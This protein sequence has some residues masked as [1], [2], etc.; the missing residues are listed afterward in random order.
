MF[1]QRNRRNRGTS[2][3]VI[4]LIQQLLT[5]GPI[6]PITL[7]F[8]I[9]Q[10]VIFMGYIPFMDPDHTHSLCLLPNVIINKKT[11]LRI[12]LPVL[13]HADDMHLYY[14]MGSLLY[15]GKNLESLLGSIKFLSIL[16]TFIVCTPLL[17][18]FL[19]Y[20]IQNFLGIDRYM[21]E[22]TVGFSGKL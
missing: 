5:S 15:K 12:I 4:L 14:N 19:A 10:V 21:H 1:Q 20:E 13:M 3:G 7:C 22:C 2:L 11:W 17:H 16:I 9:L 18:I 6:P 8:I